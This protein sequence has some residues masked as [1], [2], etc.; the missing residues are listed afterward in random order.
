V[1]GACGTHG[2]EEKNAEGF[3]LIARREDRLEDQDLDGRMGL[4]EP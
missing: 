4:I 2:R 3:G 1:G